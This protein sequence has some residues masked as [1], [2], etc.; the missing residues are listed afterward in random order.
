MN[1][2]N[3][4]LCVQFMKNK[5]VAQQEESNSNYCVCVVYYNTKLNRETCLL[6]VDFD[7]VATAVTS[8]YCIDIV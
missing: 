1:T 3:D 4:W 2:T 8:A 6:S 5:D 7:V